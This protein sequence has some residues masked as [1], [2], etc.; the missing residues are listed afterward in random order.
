M[1]SFSPG[2]CVPLCRPVLNSTHCTHPVSNPITP[3]PLGRRKPE[4]C[5]TLGCHWQLATPGQETASWAARFCSFPICSTQ[6]PAGRS[7]L[8]VPALNHWVP[9]AWARALEL[10]PV[11]GLVVG[12]LPRSCQV[13]APSICPFSRLSSNLLLET[14][15]WE[16]SI[17]VIFPSLPKLSK[18]LYALVEAMGPVWLQALVRWEGR[19]PGLLKSFRDSFG[20]L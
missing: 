16:T 4:I 12:P 10:R 1:K 2:A 15:G 5:S 19:A 17:L 8:F 3:S 7:V 18:L 11:L 9:W 6:F 13:S 20:A 14:V